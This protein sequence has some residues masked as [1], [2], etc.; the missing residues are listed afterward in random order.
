[1]GDN[2]LNKIWGSVERFMDTFV[3]SYEVECGHKIVFP[4]SFTYAILYTTASLM[5]SH[6]YYDTDKP[7]LTRKYNFFPDATYS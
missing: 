6:T 3:W 5:T 2:L 4:S 7:R 1:M